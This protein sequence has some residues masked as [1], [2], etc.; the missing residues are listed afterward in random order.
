MFEP[1]EKSED[2]IRFTPVWYVAAALI[3][4]AGIALFFTSHRITAGV[5]N[6]AGC[7]VLVFA[8]YRHKRDATK[9]LTLGS[10]SSSKKTSPR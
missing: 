9:P 10:T 4:A 7:A 5:L 1:I 6:M 2:D 3:L 8:G